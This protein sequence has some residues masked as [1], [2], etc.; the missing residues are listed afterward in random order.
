MT[1]LLPVVAFSLAFASSRRFSSSIISSLMDCD[2]FEST[3]WVIGTTFSSLLARFE[4]VKED[5]VRYGKTRLQRDSLD[6]RLTLS[7][8]GYRYQSGGWSRVS[9]LH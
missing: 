2:C 4:T 8:E 6:S 5:K 3:S 7:L 9:A 1:K